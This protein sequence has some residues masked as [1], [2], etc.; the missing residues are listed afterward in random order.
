MWAFLLGLLISLSLILI[1]L[2]NELDFCLYFLSMSLCFILDGKSDLGEGLKGNLEGVKERLAHLLAPSFQP[3]INEDEVALLAA[4]VCDAVH[5]DGVVIP[6][7][8]DRKES[9]LKAR[10]RL[11]PLRQSLI[12]VLVLVA[13]LSVCDED[14]NELFQVRVGSDQV[15]DQPECTHEVCS[16]SSSDVSESL[17]I[18]G[19]R[20]LLETHC[21]L[22]VGEGVELFERAWVSAVVPLANLLCTGPQGLDGSSGHGS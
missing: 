2:F 8:S 11:N 17:L 22:V 14:H 5:E 19:L 7:Q 9:A 6:G 4:E 15:F 16:C 13:I 20:F 18:A 3:G 10:S 21:I 12:F 1:I